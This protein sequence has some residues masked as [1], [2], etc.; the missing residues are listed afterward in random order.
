MTD[1]PNQNVTG[2]HREE[3]P[4]DLAMVLNRIEV[5]DYLD[6]EGNRLLVC[7]AEDAEGNRSPLI[8]VL[9][10]LELSK[11]TFLRLYMGEVPDEEDDDEPDEA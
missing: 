11:D 5:L 1:I 10:A 8:E 4:D 3:D 2:G 7:S 9:G 6:G